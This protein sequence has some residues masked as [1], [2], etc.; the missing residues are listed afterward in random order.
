MRRAS[1]LIAAR[2]QAQ[3][4]A[5]SSQ[6]KSAAQR[7]QGPEITSLADE[8]H[9]MAKSMREIREIAEGSTTIVEDNIV[10]L[11]ATG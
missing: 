9:A 8:L 4:E 11:A 3:L 6:L 2:A 5:G 7:A 10:P 1:A